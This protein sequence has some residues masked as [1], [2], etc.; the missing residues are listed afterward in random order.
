MIISREEID[1]K[2]K[3]PAIQN[4]LKIYLPMIG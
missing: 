3:V 4:F 1:P 2:C